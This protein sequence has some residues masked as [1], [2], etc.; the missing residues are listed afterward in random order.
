MDVKGPQAQLAS[1]L[2]EALTLGVSWGGESSQNSCVPCFSAIASD[3]INPMASAVPAS[4]MSLCHVC[5]LPGA[6]GN[7]LGGQA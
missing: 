4:W 1:L 7:A 6:E 2:G 3:P 5:P